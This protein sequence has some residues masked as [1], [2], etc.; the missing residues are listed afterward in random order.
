MTIRMPASSRSNE[1]DVATLRVT[2]GSWSTIGKAS[3]ENED[4]EYVS[5]SMDL[6]IVADGMGGNERGR[7]ASRFAVDALTHSLAG[8]RSAARSDVEVEKVVR[9]ALDHANC[10]ILDLSSEDE[11]PVGPGATVVLALLFG[12]RLFI[13]GIGDSRAYL[14][15]NDAVEELTE[16][17]TVAA[18]LQRSGHL[19]A[20][21]AMEHPLRHQ[22]LQSLGIR[23]FKPDQNIR[24]MD[25]QA[26]DRILLCSDGVS[27]VVPMDEIKMGLESAHD[28][29]RAAKELVDLALWHGTRDD[30]TCIFLRIDTDPVTAAED[31][32]P[33][34]PT[35]LGAL[36][37]LRRLFRPLADPDT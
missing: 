4:A 14:L 31:H 13:T 23:D 17:D 15:R 21:E 3:Q 12:R 7:M 25:V 30:A 11:Q 36:A 5:P 26:G 27:D 32:K 33:A 37:R 24:A 6:F 35:R 8:L 10:L 28:A 1:F 16:D 20:E 34:P 19:T 29:R 22:L 9:A 2:A 18:F